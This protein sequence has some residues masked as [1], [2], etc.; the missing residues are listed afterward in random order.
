MDS[1]S[2][3]DA[4]RCLWYVPNIA[5]YDTPS[6]DGTDLESQGAI[7]IRY[8][9]ARLPRNPDCSGSHEPEELSLLKH[10]DSDSEDEG[11]TT[12]LPKAQKYYRPNNMLAGAN[13]GLKPASWEPGMQAN[14]QWGLPPSTLARTS[15]IDT[16]TGTLKNSPTWPRND[17]GTYLPV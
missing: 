16:Q 14:P 9:R 15:S 1:H 11:S 6:F 5:T 10:R 3:R 8:Y 4:L 2:S 12:D 7:R 17:E 13:N